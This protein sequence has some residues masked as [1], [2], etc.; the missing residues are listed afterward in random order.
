MLTGGVVL[1]H[2]NIHPHTALATVEMTQQL[3]FMLFLHPTHSSD[4]TPS[5]YHIFRPLRDALC[6]CQFANNEE[7]KDTAHMWQNI[8]HGWHHEACV[9]K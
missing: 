8:L 3:K 6:G 9:L 4:F 5:D 1:H 7:V 2:N